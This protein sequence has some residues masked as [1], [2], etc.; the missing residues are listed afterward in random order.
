MRPGPCPT[1]PE[2]TMSGGRHTQPETRSRGQPT[3][4]GGTGKLVVRRPTIRTPKL[5]TIFPSSPLF[6][7]NSEF[8]TIETY[9]G[10][11]LDEMLADMD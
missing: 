5:L 10:A 9:L 7:L 4:G 2:R 6:T 3:E 1:P 8:N 11:C